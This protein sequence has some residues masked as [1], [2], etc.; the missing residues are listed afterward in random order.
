MLLILKASVHMGLDG[1]CLLLSLPEAIAS[2]LTD[3]KVRD[4]S[5][6]G[7]MLHYVIARTLPDPYSTSICPI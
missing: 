2:R 5:R 7:F 1:L 6:L 4:P 3:P